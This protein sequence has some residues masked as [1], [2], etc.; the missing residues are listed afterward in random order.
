MLMLAPACSEITS[1]WPSSFHRG[2][3]GGYAS[4]EEPE[5]ELPLPVAAPASGEDVAGALLRLLLCGIAMPSVDVMPEKDMVDGAA[6]VELVVG[7]V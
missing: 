1:N 4:E 6:G 7:A 2:R 3:P 5:S